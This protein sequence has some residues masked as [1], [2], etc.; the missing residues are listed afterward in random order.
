MSFSLVIWWRGG[1]GWG[2]AV[3]KWWSEGGKRVGNSEGKCSV[4]SQAA[5]SSWKNLRQ[6]GTSMR[7]V[8][9]RELG[10]QYSLTVYSSASFYQTP[11]QFFCISPQCGGWGRRAPQVLGSQSPGALSCSEPS[12]PQTKEEEGRQRGR[13]VGRQR[14]EEKG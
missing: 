2:S 9:Q 1:W 11:R 12:F 13:E 8:T 14:E 7:R 4:S 3:G 10:G 6:Q 5:I